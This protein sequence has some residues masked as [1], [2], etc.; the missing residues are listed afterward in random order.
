[1]TVSYFVDFCPPLKEVEFVLISEKLNCAQPPT[2]PTLLK[3]RS[4]I[5][6]T[7]EA[8]K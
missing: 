8:H 7:R 2:P 3:L 4:Y 6:T 5:A 1:M